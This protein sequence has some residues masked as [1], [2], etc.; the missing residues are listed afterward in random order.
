MDKKHAA[1]SDVPRRI[2]DLLKPRPRVQ[3]GPRDSGRSCCAQR[4]IATGT[5]VGAVSAR[6]S[7]EPAGRRRY[8]NRTLHAPKCARQSKSAKPKLSP[9]DVSCAGVADKRL[10]TVY[11]GG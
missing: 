10:R 8:E 7:K 3:A 9:Q 6:K 1:K 2:E 5:H 4:H 11:L